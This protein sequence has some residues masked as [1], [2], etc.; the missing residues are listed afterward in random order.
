MPLL[1]IWTEPVIYARRPNQEAPM[2]KD[3]F[4]LY[5]ATVLNTTEHYPFTAPNVRPRIKCRC[6]AMVNNTT[7]SMIPIAPAA[8]SD[9]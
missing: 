9:Q 7:G 3:H 2:A 4:G 8:D 6:T 1:L 5:A